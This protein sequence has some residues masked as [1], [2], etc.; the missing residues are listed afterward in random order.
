MVFISM[1]NN[2]DVVMMFVNYLARKKMKSMKCRSQQNP[3]GL[4]GKQTQ[5]SRNDQC[6]S[7]QPTRSSLDTFKDSTPCLSQE[8]G[9][10][11]AS[12]TT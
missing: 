1:F 6:I 10:M 8:E 3:S 7:S 2:I 12:K 9:V 5:P 4:T 11:P